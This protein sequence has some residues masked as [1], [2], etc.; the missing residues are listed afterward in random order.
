MLVGKEHQRINTK[1]SRYKSYKQLLGTG[2]SV[3]A[4]LLMLLRE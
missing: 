3:M 2:G 1:D 4:V